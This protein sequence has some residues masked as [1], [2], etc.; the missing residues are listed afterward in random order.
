MLKRDAEKTHLVLA[1]TIW[2]M[3]A[4]GWKNGGGRRGQLFVVGDQKE[5][6]GVNRGRRVTV[7]GIGKSV[8]GIYQCVRF[9]ERGL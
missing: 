5:E 3:K 9:G 6:V 2:G 1:E 8:T 4:R 7:R